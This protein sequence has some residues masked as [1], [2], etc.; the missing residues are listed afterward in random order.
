ML[1][2]KF[3]VYNNGGGGSPASA[4]AKHPSP[5]NFK[6]E[7]VEYAR[8]SFDDELRQTLENFRKAKEPSPTKVALQ[9]WAAEGYS[10]LFGP[11]AKELPK[12]KVTQYENPIG[13]FL[14]SIGQKIEKS[15]N[16]VKIPSFTLPEIKI[17]L[18]TVQVKEKLSRIANVIEKP[19]VKCMEKVQD[20]Y[21]RAKER[22]EEIGEYIWDLIP[23]ERIAEMVHFVAE[24]P[25][26]YI[27]PAALWIGSFIPKEAIESSF[28]SGVERMKRFATTAYD[29][30]KKGYT[31][32]EG[33]VKSVANYINT[34]FI[35]PVAN[36]LENLLRAVY[37]AIVLVCKKLYPFF[38]RAGLATYEFFKRLPS[39]SWNFM[40]LSWRGLKRLTIWLIE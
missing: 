40:K 13:P 39:R 31:F 32:C 25:Q 37:N 24:I 3:S 23:H 27:I 2:G 9:K 12:L 17:Q 8:P 16:W 29:F 15:F 11:P 19:I 6:F 34:N 38:K 7:S 14:K 21:E 22:A 35:L 30:A 5:I 33:I 18:P 20:L 28:N 4:Q 1:D 10:K 26:Q 36:W